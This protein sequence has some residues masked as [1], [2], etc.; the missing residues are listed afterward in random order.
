MKKIFRN[1]LLMMVAGMLVASCADYNEMNNFSAEPD[2]SVVTPYQ[3]YAPVKSYIDREANPNL[4]IGATLDITEF[5]KQEL[6]HSAVMTNFDNV[7]FGK[8]LMS[9]TIISDKGIMNFVNMMD[10]LEHMEEIDGTVF[11]SP[12]VANTNQAD[13]WLAMLTAPIEITVDYVEGKTMDFNSYKVG[14]QPCTNKTKQ[15]AKIVKYDGQNA[16][17]I[18][19][20]AKTNIIEGFEVDPG[21]TY[22]ITFWAKADK[23]A[24]YKVN[25][26]G[27]TIDGTATADGKWKLPSGKWTKVVVESKAAEGVTEGYL[28][29][30]MVRGSTMYIQKADVGYYPDNHQEQTAEQKNDTIMYAL[31]AWCDGFMKINEG[32]I[33]LFDLIDEAIDVNNEIEVDEKTICD[34]KHSTSSSQF[35]WQDALGSEN[36]APAVAKIAREKFTEYGGDP[37]ELK[38]FISESGLE[39]AKKM[40]SLAEWIKIWDNNGA[41]IDGI[42]A[43][44]NLSYYE[45]PEKMEECKA[46]YE[47][48]LDKLAQTGKLVRLTNFDIKYLD[49]NGLNVATTKITDEQREKLADFNAYA[50]N[51]YMKKIPKDKQSGISKSV[52]VD[53]SDPVGLWTPNGKTKDWVRT[54]TYKAWCEALSGK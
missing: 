4:E 30:E 38:F 49:A 19:S 17:N 25:F 12:I 46:A 2:P 33:K 36:Y 21:A 14:D 10:L 27:N 26:S 51:A 15:L 24:S 20:Q 23:D 54:A 6:S 37:E 29:I 5:N 35:F 41:K 22:T 31:N 53:G 43:K 52:L 42:T 7:S 39:D 34:L 44:V 11:G 48:L 32:R 9:G 18:P 3:E 40:E 28:E 47:A 8:S 13:G 45:Q 50:I 1:S 16:L